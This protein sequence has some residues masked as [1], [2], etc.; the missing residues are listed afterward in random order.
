M[1]IGIL[2]IFENKMDA[3]HTIDT[4]ANISF[5]GGKIVFEEDRDTLKVYFQMLTQMFLLKRGLVMTYPEKHE[6]CENRPCLALICFLVIKNYG[7]IELGELPSGVC[8]C[9]F[10]HTDMWISKNETK[11]LNII[12]SNRTLQ[13]AITNVVHAL[14]AMDLH[15]RD[16]SIFRTALNIK[17]GN[18]Q[19]ISLPQ[20][21]RDD[22]F[23]APHAGKAAHHR[24]RR[25]EAKP[26]EAHQQEETFHPRGNA[27]VSGVRSWSN[28][29]AVPLLDKT[30]LA[31][32]AA[33][34]ESK[35]ERLRKL[36]AEEEERLAG[37]SDVKAELER[38]K[39][40]D[41][42][43]MELEAKL[44]DVR[45][46]LQEEAGVTPTAPLRVVFPKKA[47]VIVGRK[48]APSP[49]AQSTPPQKEDNAEAEGEN[50][51]AEATAEEKK[52]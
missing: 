2:W 13:T 3:S 9:G 33:E 4:I 20:F 49:P 45:A 23:F 42:E 28:V 27:R 6:E 1:L 22:V 44:R 47:P 19:T 26:A 40:A 18:F 8:G 34:S 16:C 35:A 14:E 31:A 39:K 21:D 30:S 48:N 11:L 36:L 51:N 46:R 29:A 43:V 38:K 37:L 15:A 32:A 17:D 50:G 7:S 41:Q 12:K 5:R 10:K 25:T 24:P 52:E